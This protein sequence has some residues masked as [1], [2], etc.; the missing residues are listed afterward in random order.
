[1]SQGTNT[2]VVH[3]RNTVSYSCMITHFGQK[4]K[5]LCLGCGA[6]CR[7]GGQFCP[8]VL[9]M[10]GQQDGLLAYENMF[11]NFLSFPFRKSSTNADK[12]EYLQK[13]GLVKQNN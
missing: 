12:R 6:G 8:L 10:T 5:L 3:S 11:H 9:C 2:A 1:M 7:L 13:I 4:F